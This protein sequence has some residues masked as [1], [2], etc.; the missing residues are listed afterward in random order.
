MYSFLDSNNKSICE[1]TSKKAQTQPHVR[2]D[3]LEL[4]PCQATIYDLRSIGSPFP[5]PFLYAQ[6]APAAMPRHATG[7]LL[8]HPNPSSVSVCV[9]AYPPSFSCR[10][11]A[12][13]TPF[14]QLSAEPHVLGFAE[15][16]NM[17]LSSVPAARPKYVSGSDRTF[18]AVP[19]NL[20]PGSSPKALQDQCVVFALWPNIT[21]VYLGFFFFGVST[22]SV[23]S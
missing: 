16:R 1:V 5:C 13:Q 17:F 9:I 22:Y 23:C 6:K 7:Q 4:K 12:W 15:P 2:N 14:R 18:E 20:P 10:F 11:Q 8:T 21:L 19:G 3:H